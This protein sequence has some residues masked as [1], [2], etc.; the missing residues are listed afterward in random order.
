MSFAPV[1]M[2]ERK[3][4]KARGMR[5][6]Y[7]GRLCVHGHDA[8]RYTKSGA[9]IICTRERTAKQRENPAYRER[10]RRYNREYS[11]RPE[12]KAR[13]KERNQQHH[14]K[15]TAR[16]YRQKP[17][18]KK[19]RREAMREYSKRPEVKERLRQYRRDNAEY[20]ATH[21]RN[22]RAVEK[23]RGSHTDEDVAEILASQDGRCVYC[24]K[25]VGDDYHVD[26]VVPITKGGSNNKDNLQICCPS[27]NRH[28]SDRDPVEFAQE[29]GLLI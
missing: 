16:R 14:V 26:H 21:A 10:A 9:C 11:Q 1:P 4:A 19:K 24:R 18:V 29:M 27:C 6:Y 17:E 3:A 5:V 23:A 2:I 7:T 12:A 15:E 13:R 8:V 25:Q 22:R 20:F 28:K